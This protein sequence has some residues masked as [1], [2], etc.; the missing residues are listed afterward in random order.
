M[1]KCFQYHKTY[2]LPPYSQFFRSISKLKNN[3]YLRSLDRKSISKS[4]L[5]DDIFSLVFN[6]FSLLLKCNHDALVSISHV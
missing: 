6:C 5:R 4:M 3:P 2:I 1:L